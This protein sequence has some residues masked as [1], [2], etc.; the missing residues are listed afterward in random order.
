MGTFQVN[1]NAG[2]IVDE[3]KKTKLV[4]QVDNTSNVEVVEEVKNLKR[5]EVVDEVKDIDNIKAVQ[6]VNNVVNVQSLGDVKQVDNISAVQEVNK[7]KGFATFTQPYNIMKMFNIPANKK[8]PL[9]KKDF[10]FE[11]ELP[12]KPVEILAITM[13]CSG[14]GEDDHYDLFFN[15]IQWFKDWYCSEV[16]EGLFLG[17]STYVYEAAPK[18]KIKLIFKNDSGSQKKIW[19]GIRM[20]T[21]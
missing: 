19:L 12:D 6:D 21:K 18:S 10:E 15:G 20:L 4:E 1:Y 5:A 13:T 9:T 7:I 2:G 11:F 17:T 14:Y 8:D 16:K 3:V